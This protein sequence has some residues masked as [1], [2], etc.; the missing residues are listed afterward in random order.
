MS[1][2]E[3]DLIARY[4]TPSHYS[5]DVRL[6]VG[7]DAAVLDVPTGFK[8]V[9][10]VD[11]LVEGVHFPLDTHPR[12]IAYR[13]L[14]VNLS[15]L[16]AMGAQPRWFTLSLC[17]PNTN[18]TWLAEFA[19]GLTEL[20]TQFNVQLVGGDTVKG[21]LNISVQILG[22]VEADRWLT[23]SG[24]QPGDVIFVSGVPGE[25]AA[26][27]HSILH[28]KAMQSSPTAAQHHDYLVQRFLQPTPR[29]VLGRALRMHASATLDVSDGLLTDLKKLCAASQC[30]AQLDLESLPHSTA[31]HAL[32]DHAQAEQFA[33]GGGDDYE[34][35][36]TVH[37]QQLLSLESAIADCGVRC[38]P[39]GRIIAGDAVSCCRA[40]CAVNVDA[41]GY[42]HF[43]THSASR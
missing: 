29:V 41:T 35:L 23:R 31:M 8:L 20:A 26:G 34:L 19:A 7:D 37:P 15:D 10:A 27:L 1:L 28:P 9:A 33:L 6:G 17:L 36:F 3:F 13:A 12:D 16:A 21:P 18:E 2:G 5:A 25:A 39:I 11:T 32:F 4:F 38:T 14:A 40:G 22:C 30:G 24:A 43:A 42:D